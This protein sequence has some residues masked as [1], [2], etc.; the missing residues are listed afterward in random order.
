MSNANEIQVA[1]DHY[2]VHGDNN[3]QH[4]DMVAVFNLDYFQGQIT[5]YVMRWKHKNGIE[6]L[7]KAA[8]FLQKYIELQTPVPKQPESEPFCS[9]QAVFRFADPLDENT[10]PVKTFHVGEVAPTG[11]MQFTFEGGDAEGALYT[12][13][14]CKNK[15]RA[16]FEQ[17][18]HD[19]HGCHDIPDQC[20]WTWI[21]RKRNG[22]EG[23]A[24]TAYV[25]QD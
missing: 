2:R 16:P 17:N 20:R 8:H 22:V 25:N 9:P 4:W 12:C 3:L 10:D 19:Y 5:K 14:T 7:Q 1:G 11:W 6:D 15:F 21:D 23:D 18:P 13:R 24:T